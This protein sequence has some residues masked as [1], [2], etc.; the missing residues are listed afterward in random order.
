MFFLLTLLLSCCVPT[1][2]VTKIKN[3]YSPVVVRNG[4]GSSSTIKH[5]DSC[6]YVTANHV[7]ENNKEFYDKNIIKKDI[8]EI[9]SNKVNDLFIFKNN[10]CKD[11][12]EYNEPKEL[13]HGDEIHYWCMPG[14]SELKYFKGY[15]SEVENDY[16]TIFA[17]SWFGCS[18]AG[19]F[20]KDN[21]FIGVISSMM[22][23]PN[24]GYT[25]YVAHENIVKVSIFKKEYIE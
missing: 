14:G 23:T 1:D 15:I 12:I 24:A 20:T 9:Y 13:K 4:F 2:N 22:A 25:D 10:E 21:E 18:G 5:K 3:A 8:D 6:Y 19:V 7:V 11:Y 17:Y 16:I